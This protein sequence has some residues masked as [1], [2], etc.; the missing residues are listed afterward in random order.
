MLIIGGCE[1]SLER[2]PFDSIELIDF[3]KKERRVLDQRL[4]IP[5]RGAT[6][7]VID[8]MLWVIGGCKGPKDH[9]KDIQVLDLTKPE[10]GFK[11]LPVM[12]NKERSC[13]MSAYSQKHH[14]LYVLGGF[15][16]YDCLNSV[17]VLDCTKNSEFVAV[18][19]PMPSRIKNGVAIMNEDD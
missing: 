6:A 2:N 1:L 15:D 4:C 14:K 13:H 18:K 19:D 9:M 8:N 17:E 10:A 5:A 3:E 11:L 7:H 12:L 16:G